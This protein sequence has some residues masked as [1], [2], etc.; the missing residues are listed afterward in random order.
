MNTL[1]NASKKRR[2][3]MNF[4]NSSVQYSQLKD[5]DEVDSEVVSVPDPVVTGRRFTS[6]PDHGSSQRESN[7]SGENDDNNRYDEDEE[8]EKTFKSKPNVRK[9]LH[10]IAFLMFLYLLQGVPLGLTGSLPFI[11]GARNVSYTDQGTFS[12]AFWPFCLKL[13]W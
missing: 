3:T 13:L 2:T 8:E 9:D 4:Q 11:L 5:Y 10:N 12:F 6:T 7:F 1:Y